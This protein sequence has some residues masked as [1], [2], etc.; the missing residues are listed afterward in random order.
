MLK[1]PTKPDL[2]L[3]LLDK[4]AIA[5]PMF[6]AAK[7]SGRENLPAVDNLCD[8]SVMQEVHASLKKS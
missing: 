5:G 2:P 6:A 7:A 4:D 3:L 8:F 1:S